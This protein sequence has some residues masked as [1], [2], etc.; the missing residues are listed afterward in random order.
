[1]SIGSTRDLLYTVA[2]ILG[3]VQAVK[4][5][6]VGKRIGRRVVGKVTKRLTANNAT[7]GNASN[8]ATLRTPRASLWNRYR[9][10]SRLRNKHLLL[11]TRSRNPR[12]SRRHVGCWLH[13]ALRE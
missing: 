11:M 2:R 8:T 7:F 10:G 3:D 5:G 13:L 4:K 6:R 12:R 1:M 9:V